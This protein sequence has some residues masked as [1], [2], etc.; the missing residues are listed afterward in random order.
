LSGF[1]RG[2]LLRRYGVLRGRTALRALAFEALV[3]AWGLV[4]FRTV[5]PLTARVRGWRAGG[6]ER[7][8]L[9]ADAVDRSIGWRE[10][11]RRLRN[12]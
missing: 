3:V 4:R 12:P 1:A 5:V 6:G 9:P 8:A 10:A 7:R 2:Y 11:F